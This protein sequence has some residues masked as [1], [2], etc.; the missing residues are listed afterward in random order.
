MEG[1]LSPVAALWRPQNS[2]GGLPKRPAVVRCTR[3]VYVNP[4]GVTTEILRSAATHVSAM[5]TGPPREA[6][7][8]V[9]AR[10]ANG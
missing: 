7:G 9:G 3:V 2:P 1:L 10:G 4:Q 5:T 8:N 6:I